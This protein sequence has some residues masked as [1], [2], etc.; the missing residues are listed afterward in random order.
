MDW[1]KVGDRPPSAPCR[2]FGMGTILSVDGSAPPI[3]PMNDTGR[4]PSGQ[5][6]AAACGG[7]S[8]A[9]G[10]GGGTGGG[11]AGGTGCGDHGPPGTSDPA[12]GEGGRML[13]RIV[14]CCPDGS[15]ESSGSIFR[16]QPDDVTGKWQYILSVSIQWST[17]RGDR[18]RVDHFDSCGPAF[19]PD[20]EARFSR[21]EPG[22]FSVVNRPTV[23]RSR[24]PS[25]TTRRPDDG[26]ASQVAGDRRI[27]GA[28]SG[29]AAGP[30]PEPARGG[31][32]RG[33]SQ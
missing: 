20:T 26:S 10:P 2:Q 4:R 15:R 17:M 27:G 28:E 3:R 22:P 21:R 19:P 11:H 1:R 33:P 31:G 7:G 30:H 13:S 29:P 23:V 12:V 8:G 16:G 14:R 18:V 24:W 5:G 9:R 25:A 6:G 32:Q